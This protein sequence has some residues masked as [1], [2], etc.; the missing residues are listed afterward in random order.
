MFHFGS[1]W[2]KFWLSSSSSPSMGSA[3]QAI[4]SLE[5]ALKPGEEYVQIK[6]SVLSGKARAGLRPIINLLLHYGFLKKRKSYLNISIL[7]VKKCDGSFHLDLRIINLLTV[8]TIHPIV[9]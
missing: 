9:R 2:A 7:P 1:L 6:Q 8:K 5:I 4:Q 3:L